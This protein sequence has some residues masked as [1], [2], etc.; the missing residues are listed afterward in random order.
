MMRVVTAFLGWLLLMAVLPVTALG[1]TEKNEV[2]Y[3]HPPRFDP[4]ITDTAVPL[5]PNKLCLEYNCGLSFYTHR[6][7]RNWRQQSAGGDYSSLDME[8]KISYGLFRDC[9]IYVTLPFEYNWAGDVNQ[10]GPGGERSS[11]FGG[12]DDVNL[13]I[14]YQLLAEGYRVPTITGLV[15]VDFPTGRYRNLDPGRLGTDA[16]GDGVYVLTGGLNFF[17]TLKPVYLYANLWYSVQTAY[18][19]EDTESGLDPFNYLYHPRDYL[20]VNLAIDYALTAKWFAKLEVNSYW[21]VGNLSGR[22]FGGQAQAPY[23]ALITVQPGI[24]FMAT[25]RFSLDL[26]VGIDAWGKKSYRAITP[27]LSLGYSFY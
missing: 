21:D 27:L 25:D 15:A 14:K 3:D 9:E 19:Y 11:T 12:L 1:G 24:G 20:T 18:D 7:S 6:L 17:K 16:I 8:V 2:G 23:T 13:T 10:P 22:I 5:H 26:G 4:I